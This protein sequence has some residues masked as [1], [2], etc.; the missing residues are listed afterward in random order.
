MIL[1]NTKYLKELDLNNTLFHFDVR[2]EDYILTHGFPPDRGK[3]SE[4]AEITKKVFFSK[5]ISGVLNLIDV[6]IIW[7]M[8]KEYYSFPDW[9]K[10]FISGSFIEDREKKE[11]IFNIMIDW[12]KERT[13]YKLDLVEGIDYLSTDVDE[14]KRSAIDNRIE[15][16]N[17]ANIPWK[18]LYT[19]VMYN[20]SFSDYSDTVE[21]WNMHTLVN[22]GVSKGKITK[23]VASNNETDAL[24]I[25]EELY[26]MYKHKEDFRLLNEFI[27]YYQ[28]K[29]LIINHKS[30]CYIKKV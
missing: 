15:C 23:L 4:N 6:W 18:Y 11:H 10:E 28:K 5:G 7:R 26:S 20:N 27:E 19:S 22:Q 14:A 1:M 25:I 30:S 3:D 13:Y 29:G 12:L 21:E 2:S 17:T 24:S 8:N 16:K 9:S